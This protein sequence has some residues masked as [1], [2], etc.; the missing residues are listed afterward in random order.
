M[1]EYQ[2]RPADGQSQG[3]SSYAQRLGRGQRSVQSSSQD[4]KLFRM[5]MEKEFDKQLENDDI[6]VPDDF[7]NEEILFKY[8]IELMEI[9]EDEQEINL[10]RIQ[11]S[12]ENEQIYE[13]RKQQQ[14]LKEEEIGK[15]ISTQEAV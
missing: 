1:S 6:D 13:L 7:Y 10:D 15:E 9:F 8:P 3:G 11:K 2:K 14:K 5:K 4:E 12:Q